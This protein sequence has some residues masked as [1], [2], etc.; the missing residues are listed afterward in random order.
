MSSLIALSGMRRKEIL[1]IGY[2]AGGGE[3]MHYEAF[4]IIR[5]GQRR[6]GRL[7]N[8]LSLAAK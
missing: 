2:D 1:T 5:R 4:N 6:Q 3:G 8:Q 7:L